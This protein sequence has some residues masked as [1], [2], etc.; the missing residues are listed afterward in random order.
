M[1]FKITAY[2]FLQRF[3]ITRVTHVFAFDLQ[4]TISIARLASFLSKQFIFLASTA[5]LSV[6]LLNLC[7]D[8]IWMEYRCQFLLNDTK[9]FVA[10]H[11]QKTTI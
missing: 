2:I 7:N 1:I 6:C 8:C 3:D 11:T 5:C 9:D 4:N 10:E